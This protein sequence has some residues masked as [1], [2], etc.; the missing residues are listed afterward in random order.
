[1]SNYANNNCKDGEGLDKKLQ[2]NVKYLIKFSYC[3]FN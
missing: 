2:V 3:N 1:M